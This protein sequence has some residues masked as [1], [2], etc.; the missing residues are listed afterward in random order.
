MFGNNVCFMVV[1]GGMVSISLPGVE[2]RPYG[3]GYG[4]RSPPDV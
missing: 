2:N 3:G 1:G 4:S